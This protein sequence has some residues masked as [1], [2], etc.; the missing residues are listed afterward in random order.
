MDIMTCSP[1]STTNSTLN[2]KK[3]QQKCY[4]NSACHHSIF[5]D[6]EN[7]VGDCFICSEELTEEIICPFNCI[8][9]TFDKSNF[10]FFE[11]DFIKK[12]TTFKVFNFL[13]FSSYSRH[14]ID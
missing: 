13:N 4:S 8:S 5:S 14:Y 3:C 7:S 10:F 12:H 9:H 1:I 2:A 6:N 11:F